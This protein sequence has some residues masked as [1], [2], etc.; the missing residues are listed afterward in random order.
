VAKKKLNLFEFASDLMAEA[1]AS[2]TKIVRSQ[3]VNADS[4]GVSPHGIPDY[5]GC[6]SFALPSPSLRNSSEHF[7]FRHS[8]VVEPSIYE[9]FTP[10][11]RGDHSQPS[12]LP[13][14]I[15]DY[16]MAFPQLQLIQS[17][18]HGFRASQTATEQQSD[19]CY[20][21]AAARGALGNSI[22]QLLCLIGS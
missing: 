15:Y 4:L 9:G 8:S 1:G 21:S 12:S 7:A 22:Q 5:V 6:H 14:H 20:I 16:P 10:G 2:A 18:L 17:Q 19:H 13:N 11:R 3:M